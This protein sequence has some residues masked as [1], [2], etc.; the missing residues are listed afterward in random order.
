[1]TYLDDKCSILSIDLLAP[2]WWS[3]CSPR[4]QLLNWLAIH[5]VAV[6]L[7]CL[8]RDTLTSQQG[9]SAMQPTPPIFLAPS[10]KRQCH[11]ILDWWIFLLICPWF[12]QCRHF[13][14]FRNPTHQWY[15]WHWWS[16]K[17]VE[18]LGR[19][20]EKFNMAANAVSRDKAKLIS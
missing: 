15:R 13:K 3:S 14:L 9:S 12:L 19:L 2:H 18:S 7:I 10:L 16:I 5:S 17:R 11:E 4:P 20:L 6:F 1:M 8:Q